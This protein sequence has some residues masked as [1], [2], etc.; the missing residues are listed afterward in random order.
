MSENTEIHYLAA[1]VGG[2]NTQICL[3]DSTSTVIKQHIYKTQ[4]YPSLSA[5]AKDFVKDQQLPIKGCFALAGA[6]IDG[7]C[8][9]TNVGWQELNQETLSQELGFE[10]TLI[11]DFVALGYNIAFDKNK[12]ATFTLQTGNYSV[13]SPIAIIGAGTGLGKCFCIPVGGKFLVFP[14][15]GGHG[16]YASR[17]TDED[18]ILTSLRPK[19]Q[20]LCQEKFNLS[21]EQ[22][23]HLSVDEEAILSGPGI[24][25]IFHVL[26][27]DFPESLAEKISALPTDQ[28]PEAIAISAN[29]KTNALAEKTMEVF[30]EAYGAICGNFAV[31]LLPFG[32]LYIAG[33]IAAKNLDLIQGKKDLFLNAFNTKVRVNPEL[34]KR[35]P[36]EI[37]TDELSGLQGAINYV[38]KM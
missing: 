16:D 28:Q 9:L 14:S 24:A 35:V 6:V 37:V 36:I 19:Y 31:N 15:E 5:I 30:I 29:K 1:D 3:V 8:N 7:K 13:S 22:V 12:L 27:A 33:G 10:V 32:G 38:T 21:S 25:D 20:A 2:T 4:D 34:L 23:K 26:K 18:N 17:N 11:N